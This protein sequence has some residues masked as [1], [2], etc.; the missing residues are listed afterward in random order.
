MKLCLEDFI[1]K[2]LKKYDLDFNDFLKEIDDTQD[3]PS[4]F[5]DNWELIDS[6]KENI[7]LLRQ[8]L[9][10]YYFNRQKPNQWIVNFFSFSKENY[11]N[12]KFK[13]LYEEKW[14]RRHDFWMNFHYDWDHTISNFLKQGHNIKD[15]IP[16]CPKINKKHKFKKLKI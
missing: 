5:F 11:Y 7:R 4:I 15:I 14:I 9:L 10:K 6:V 1:N 8:L 3:K 13:Y 12:P 16:F 2:K